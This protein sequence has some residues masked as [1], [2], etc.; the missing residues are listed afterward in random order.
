MRAWLV[1]V[2]QVP[3]PAVRFPSFQYG[4][5]L[6]KFQAMTPEDFAD[7]ARRRP[8]KA[9]FYRGMGQSGF[10]EERIAKA[11][12]DIRNTAARMDLMLEKSGGPWLLGEQFTLA[13]I[14]VAP[15]LDRIEDLCFA[16]LWEEDFPRVAGWLG[17]IQD[18]PSFK[19]AYYKG[20]R[21][22]DIYPDLKLGRAAPRSLPKSWP[23]SANWSS[24]S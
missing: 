5:L 17:R 23:G 7:L 15:L 24:A 4:G 13:D 22:S 11:L 6:R 14:C 3:T 16:H 19:Q 9:D 1:F 2:D 20:S 12:E 21:L 8:L 18:R 10:S